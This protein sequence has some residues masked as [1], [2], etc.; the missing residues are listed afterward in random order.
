MQREIIDERPVFNGSPSL[1]LAFQ[2]EMTVCDQRRKNPGPQNAQ[3]TKLL[4][5]GV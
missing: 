1:L 5:G 2:N 3:E 4:L